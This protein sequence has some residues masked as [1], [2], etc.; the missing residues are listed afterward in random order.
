MG[1]MHS[2][3]YFFGPY[4][5]ARER[6]VDLFFKSIQER[7][8]QARSRIR[9]LKL[10]QRD[11]AVINLWTEYRYKGYRY[12]HKSQRKQLYAN[13]DRITQD[14]DAYYSARKKP[15]ASIQARIIAVAP[16]T[17]VGHDE[18]VVLQ[19]IMD[20][21]AP[22]RG[23]YEYRE[24]SSFGRL[25]Q[26]PATFKLVGD[27]NQI[28]TLYIYM[29]SRYYDVSCLQLRVLPEHVALHY[30]GVDVEATTS[31][32]ANYDKTKGQKIVPVEEIVS[33]NLLDTTD[34]YLRTHEVSATDFLQASRF[35]VALSYNQSIARRNLKVAYSR[36]VVL[37]MKQHHHTQ[38]L[39]Y[40]IASRDTELIGAVGNNA[41]VHEMKRHNYKSALRFAKFAP[42]RDV[43]V[44]QIWRSMGMRYYKAQNYQNAAQAF[45]RS[46]DVA[47]IAS[48]YKALFFDEQAKL[49]RQPSTRSIKKYSV[50][51]KR[52]HRYAKKSGNKQLLKHANKLRREL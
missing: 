21:F 48:C 31:T 13:L 22:R 43:L 6:A 30:N 25:L 39:R 40:A 32:F 4:T 38:A 33:I 35:A 23:T 15:F 24:S 28:V 50:P 17:N 44:L 34:A 18:I 5:D 29:F 36:L 10:V 46:K 9:L 49:A 47:L 7:K 14:F 16:R 52:M 8:H 2:L 45:K 12:L 26:D 27:C 1:F 19:A 20:Y 51:I 11:I 42:D 3:Y 37:M 41:A